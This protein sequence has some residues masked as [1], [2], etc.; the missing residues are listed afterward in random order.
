M[1]ADSWWWHAVAVNHFGYK[2]W[3]RP[4]AFVELANCWDLIVKHCR[5]S[6]FISEAPQVSFDMMK[7]VGL[8][9]K[10][11]TELLELDSEV[12]TLLDSNGAGELCEHRILHAYTA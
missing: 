2:L 11:L 8:A 9:R 6:W 7:A 3:H 1:L 10:G 5:M 12:S 4:G